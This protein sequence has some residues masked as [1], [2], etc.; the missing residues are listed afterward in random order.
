[1]KVQRELTGKTI[2]LTKEIASGG[3]GIVYAIQEESK[4][5]AKIYRSGKLSSE[6]QLKLRAMLKNPLLDLSMRIRGHITITW[7]IDLLVD[8]Q[9]LKFVGYL[10]PKLPQGMVALHNCYNA[11][12]R[13]KK[14]PHFHY[15]SLHKVALNL[16]EIVSVIHRNEYVI[17]DI[18][19]SNICVGEK[20]VVTII[21]TDSFQVRDGS[22][23][24]RCLVAKGEYVPPELSL[25]L[26]R[27]GKSYKDI[28]RVVEHDLF[29]L[30]V[31][32]FQ[33]LMNGTHP[34]DGIYTGK[35]EQPS[36][37]ERIAAGYFPYGKKIVPFKPR[38]I[39]PPFELLH[40]ELRELF[41][42]CFE[43]GYS[44]PR[45]RP[46]AEEWQKVLNKADRN[47]VRC[48]LVS[49]H[50]Y[51]NHLKVCPWCKYVKDTKVNDPFS[52]SRPK[53]V[54]AVPVGGVS[55][56]PYISSYPTK[57]VQ[58]APSHIFTGA[59][60][61]T[62]YAVAVVIVICT[63]SFLFAQ[64]TL[65]KSLLVKNFSF[66]AKDIISEKI[67]S[68]IKHYTSKPDTI[69]TVDRIDSSSCQF[70]S[71]IGIGFGNV[72]L[73]SGQSHTMI[74]SLM[75]EASGLSVFNLWVKT[76]ET[77]PSICCCELPIYGLL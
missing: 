51:G 67:F 5:V 19:E 45:V 3:E 57:P 18:N 76:L 17:G 63:L 40:P 74:V 36:K 55:K 70:S 61:N 32:M 52:T 64:Q 56:Q 15:G 50:Y 29:G 68:S 35:G 33:L 73:K 48:S 37:P 6:H 59:V 38:P 31:I 30:A 20:S 34:F 62:R 1:M 66:N 28:D 14:L 44:N 26:K 49:Q 21:D 60:G 4:L 47:L 12:D 46:T 27:L 77:N 9:T 8:P 11:N 22:K 13:R 72:Q 71:A 23:T 54:Q 75:K 43:A 42:Q 2:T 7:V 58:N 24:Y 10:M 65:I 39:A 16:A 41:V 53:S 69:D 25:L